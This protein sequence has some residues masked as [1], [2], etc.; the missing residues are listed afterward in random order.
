MISV[1]FVFANLKNDWDYLEAVDR[2]FSL[3]YLKT[4]IIQ[5]IL[6]VRPVSKLRQDG[7]QL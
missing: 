6:F 4:E 5:M 3:N 7:E 2:Y 1:I